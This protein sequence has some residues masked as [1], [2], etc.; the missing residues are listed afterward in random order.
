VKFREAVRLAPAHARYKVYIIDEVHQLSS[1]AFN[2][3]LKTLEE[4]P[5]HAVFILAT[6]EAHTKFQPQLYLD[7]NGMIFAESQCPILF[8]C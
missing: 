6:T 7:V 2:A 5:S 8:I 1:A 4:P 3:L